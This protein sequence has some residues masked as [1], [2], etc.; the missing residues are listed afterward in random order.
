MASIFVSSRNLPE[1]DCRG[2]GGPHLRAPGGHASHSDHGFTGL[3]DPQRD[4]HK[5]SRVTLLPP[6]RYLSTS[7]SRADWSTSPA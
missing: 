6:Q 3:G 5:E 7:F 2:G 4:L 1:R